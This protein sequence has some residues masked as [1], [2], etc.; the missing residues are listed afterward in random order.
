MSFQR[1]AP[2]QHDTLDGVPEPSEHGFLFGHEATSAMLAGA[3]RAAKLHHALLLAGPAG[4]GKA[5][6]AFRLAHHL[7]VNPAGERA[8][9][10]LVQP[11]PSSAIFRSVAQGAHPSVLHL[12]RPFDER[13]K[14]FKT[15]ISV[16]E[17]RRV[18]RFLS[19]TAHDGGWRTVIVDPADDL[20]TAAAN[21][22]L[23]NLE[24][25]PAKTVFVL[26]THRP[27]R[28][29]P[30]I[31]SRCQLIQLSPLTEQEVSQAF[32]A[33]GLALPSEPSQLASLLARSQGSVRK[34]I[35]LTEYGGLEIADA[36]DGVLAARVFDVAA[37]VRVA[38]AV[39]GRDRSQQFGMLVEHLEARLGDAAGRHA[40][41]GD[42]TAAERIANV[43]TEFVRKG[44][45]AEAYNLDRRQYVTD[46]LMKVHSALAA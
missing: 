28:L 33:L 7:L 35:M 36:V 8:P 31:R 23:K 38:D 21:A 10:S 25:P 22:L 9:G 44:A 24:E 12:T 26:V 6:L 3:Y 46:S 13:T 42:L 19:M 40:L 39:N 18:S 1:L 29:L 32:G 45:E 41:G 34:A 5:T 16:D 43:W 11:D 37:A 4:I 2:R 15:V 14:K 27:G 30:T 17:V 20:N